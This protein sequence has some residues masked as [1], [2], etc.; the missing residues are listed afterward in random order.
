[1]CAFLLVYK[2]LE[3]RSITIFFK[4][5]MKLFYETIGWLIYRWYF[6]KLQN[7]PQILQEPMKRIL[8]RER[9]STCAIE[10][11]GLLLLILIAWMV[12]VLLYSENYTEN[13]R[14]FSWSVWKIL[15][16]ALLFVVIN[17][18]NPVATNSKTLLL[19]PLGSETELAAG[20]AA[21]AIRHRF[22]M[23]AWAHH[24]VW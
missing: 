16:G 2:I 20:W 6:K 12:G 11:F 15:L 24:V 22:S 3:R 18:P 1:M 7:T 13:P 10:D 9:E 21:E 4:T 14:F 5:K 23:I 19:V 17:F 8:E